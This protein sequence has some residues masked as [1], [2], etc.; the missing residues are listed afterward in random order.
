MIPSLENS[1]IGSEMW[2]ACLILDLKE[3]Q[4]NPVTLPL[5]VSKSGKPPGMVDKWLDT[6]FDWGI[7][8]SEILNFD[9]RDVW[10]YSIR[11]EEKNQISDILWTIRGAGT[12]SQTPSGSPDLNTLNSEIAAISAATDKL[13]TAYC[14]KDNPCIKCA[15]YGG[16]RWMC[17]LT[18]LYSTIMRLK[19]IR[20]NHIEQKNNRGR[21]NV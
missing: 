9:G 20:N 8:G 12:G 2:L 3:E 14:V 15:I 16:E 5:L 19:M 4:H 11:P 17:P 18:A 6:L 21:D 7:I 1:K 13:A 10:V